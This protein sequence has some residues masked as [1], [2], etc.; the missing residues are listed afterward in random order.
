MCYL[1]NLIN[2][3]S[4]EVGQVTAA[5]SEE[6]VIGSY[7]GKVI[8]FAPV[9]INKPTSGGPEEVTQVI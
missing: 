3:K 8:S 5:G 4:L 9:G 7:S 1:I 2:P 6:L